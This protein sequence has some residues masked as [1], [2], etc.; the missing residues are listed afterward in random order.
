MFDSKVRQKKNKEIRSNIRFGM[1]AQAKQGIDEYIE[2]YGSDCYVELERARYYHK[3]REYETAVE[4]LNNIIDAGEKNIGY[5][6]FELGKVYQEMQEYD[7]AIETFKKVEETNHQDKSYALFAL[8]IL[9]EKS[10]RYF[11]AIECF[12]K[13]IKA[14]DELREKAK[15]HL[16]RTYI[17]A[18]KFNKARAT[19]NSVITQNDSKTAKLIIYYDAKIDQSIGLMEE[20]E[21]KIDNLLN[22]DPD[23]NAALA[24]KARILMTKKRYSESEPY[25]KKIK[26]GSW[27]DFSANDLAILKCEYYERTNQFEKALEMYNDLLDKLDGSYIP[28]HLSRI[29][30]GIAVCCVGLGKIDEGYNHFTEECM[31]NGAFK[32]ACLYNLISIDLYRGNYEKAKELFEE[33]NQYNIGKAARSNLKTLR[34]MVNKLTNGELP[35]RDEVSYRDQQVIEYSKELAIDHIYYGHG[36]ETA[37]ANEGTFHKDTNISMLMDE[38]KEKLNDDNIV[39]INVLCKYRLYYENVGE[40]NGRQLNYLAV[41]TLPFSNDIITMYPTNEYLEEQ[42]E[43]QDVEPVKQKNIKRESQIEKFNRRYNLNGI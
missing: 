38:I 16:G 29:K 39:D 19:L 11:D 40:Y 24:E 31:K 28:L 8:G 15:F 9:Y 21:A 3:I 32:N 43:V 17:Y 36:K 26:T 13:V 25:I 20:Y 2:A 5:A 14:S 22:M 1:F 6:L 35:N 18:K 33:I 27:D 10:F 23:F 30:M 34:I 41:V 7:K 37:P 4:I 12:E 42:I